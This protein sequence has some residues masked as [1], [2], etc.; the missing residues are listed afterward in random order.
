M[1]KSF[2]NNDPKISIAQD[3]PRLSLG[4]LGNFELKSFIKKLNKKLRKLPRKAPLPFS[5]QDPRLKQV[6]FQFATVCIEILN[7][8]FS[9]VANGPGFPCKCKPGGDSGCKWNFSVTR[10]YKEITVS[11]IPLSSFKTGGSGI[12]PGRGIDT[13]EKWL[14]DMWYTYGNF[15]GQDG[16]IA[17]HDELSTKWTLQDMVSGK[18]IPLSDLTQLMDWLYEADYILTTKPPAWAPQGAMFEKLVGYP[19]WWIGGKGSTGDGVIMIKDEFGKNSINENKMWN[20]TKYSIPKPGQGGLPQT[21][22]SSDAGCPCVIDFLL[23]RFNIAN[24]TGGER[25]N[26][27]W[28]ITKEDPAIKISFEQQECGLSCDATPN[29]KIPCEESCEKLLK[30][31]LDLMYEMIAEKGL[32]KNKKCKF[33]SPEVKM[34]SAEEG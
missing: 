13:F 33:E 29:C 12:W 32:D 22:P 23:K 3:V 19:Y 28:E 11:W 34:Y 31:Y 26:K 9:K 1:D 15:I 30:S 5:I 24:G 17:H 10:A 8:K 27:P 14:Y 6:N 25:I 4:S 2:F 20:A 18:P 16:S 21:V 7:G